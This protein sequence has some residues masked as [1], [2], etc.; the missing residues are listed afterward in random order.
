MVWC[1]DRAAIREAHMNG[2]TLAELI[3]ANGQSVDDFIAA[4][5]S[6]A[7]ER[8]NT[9]IDNGRITEERAAEMIATLEER[10]T[11]LVNGEFAQWM[12]PVPADD[13][14][15]AAADA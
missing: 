13:A 8:I 6:A 5:V 15:A 4:A 1:W 11:A 3:E 7:S 2:Q 14:E 12:P 10:L 9:A